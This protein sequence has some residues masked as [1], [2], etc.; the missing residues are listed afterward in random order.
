M[1]HDDGE[2][3]VKEHEATG[4]CVYNQEVDSRQDLG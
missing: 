2:N 3:M 4:L 1:A